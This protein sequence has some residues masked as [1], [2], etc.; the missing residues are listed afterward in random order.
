MSLD[1]VEGTRT[2]KALCA[3][4][5]SKSAASTNCATTPSI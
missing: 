4:A 3:P 1:G 5:E 2:P